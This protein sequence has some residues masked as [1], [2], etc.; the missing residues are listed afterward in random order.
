MM[1]FEPSGKAFLPRFARWLALFALLVQ[2]VAS[3]GHIHAEDYRFLL[4]GHSATVLTS[5][6]GPSGGTL[7]AL[8]PDTDCAICASAHLLGNGAL[9]DVPDIRAVD[10]QEIARIAIT[11]AF[12]LTP[13]R[14]LLFSTRAPPRL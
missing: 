13:P 6:D 4:R 2:L 8:A 10:G 11:A 1:A 14:H 12:W 9:P 5:G 7:P 3:F